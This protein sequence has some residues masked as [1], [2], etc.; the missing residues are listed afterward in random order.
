MGIKGYKAF[1]ADLTCLGFQYK[2]GETYEKADCKLCSCGFHF[3]TNIADCFKYYS[4]GDARFAEVEALGKII[5]SKDDSKCVTDKIRI[6]KEI[7][8]ATAVDMSNSGNRNSGDCNSGDYNSGDR[9][10]GNWNSGDCNSG[11]CNSGDRNSGNCNSGDWNKCDYSAGCFNTEIQTIT[12]FNKPSTWTMEDYW[13][14]TAY[15]ILNR[16]PG[17]YIDLIW[18]Y[19]ADMTAE[20]K[21]AHPDHETTGG[22][23]KSVK[24]E[25]DRQEWWNKLTK[26]EK[27]EVM[28]L[29][30]FDAEIFE[31]CTG[32]C[33]K[34]E[35]E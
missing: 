12:M 6:V 8:R 4:S 26:R 28:G 33:V 35:R 5:R 30:N 34:G 7:P 25:A 22:F 19:S 27:T 3:C 20:E 14:S 29:P 1:N 13:K 31:E 11:D 17:E 24:I 9:N 21:E 10:S 2:I 23:L 18:T 16:M 15:D 32:I